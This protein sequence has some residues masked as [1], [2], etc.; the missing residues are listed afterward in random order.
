MN[1]RIG[2]NVT[3]SFFAI[4]L[5]FLY[6]KYAPTG[7]DISENPNILQENDYET[8]GE[9]PKDNGDQKAGAGYIEARVIRVIDGDTIVLDGGEVL[10]YIGIDSP[11]TKDP[12]R[13]VE[14][15]GNEAS[16]INEEL[17]L[18]K[19]VKLEKDVSDRDKYGRL[20]RYVWVSSQPQDNS[21]TQ[22]IFVNDYLVR[23]GYAHAVTYPPDVRYSELFRQSEAK[24]RE[25]G[26]GLWSEC[27][28]NNVNNEQDNSSN[29][30]ITQEGNETIDES[31]VDCSQNLYNCSDFKTK[32][33]AQSVY[34]ACGESDIHRLD[35]DG[36][37][38]ACESFP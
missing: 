12:R 29:N 13:E 1:W 4:F 15:Y 17:V 28:G 27:A 30:N 32:A 10:R 9:T 5:L 21:G 6:L 22:E 11:E 14:C 33:E 25:E 37:G 8:T 36:D 7:N 24:A 20:L 23:E 16:K 18:G 35:S 26:K 31:N 19:V 34:D 38:V 2:K 3:F